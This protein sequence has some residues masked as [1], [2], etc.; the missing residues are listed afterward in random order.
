[1]I[2]DPMLFLAEEGVPLVGGRRTL[3]TIRELVNPMNGRAMHRLRESASGDVT[4]LLE[5]DVPLV[6]RR[7]VEDV[8]FSDWARGGSQDADDAPGEDDDE[9]EFLEL[10]EAAASALN[11]LVQALRQR[12]GASLGVSG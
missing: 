5:A 1:M 3:R 8:S 6:R 9:Q 4:D 10:V 11:A 12:A 2:S 7:S